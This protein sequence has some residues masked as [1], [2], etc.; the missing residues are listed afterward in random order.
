MSRRSFG[1]GRPFKILLIGDSSVGKTSLMFR[2]SDDKFT[3]TF[4]PTIGIDFKLK[5]I[6]IRDK[7]I[8]LQLWDTAGQERFYNIVR[9]YYRNADAI[10]LVYD[11]T[12]ACTFQNIVRWMKSINENAPDDVF[13]V[14][15]GNKSDLHEYLVVS[16]EDGRQLANQYHMNYFETSAKSDSIEKITQMFSY[17]TETL[18]ERRQPVSIPPSIPINKFNESTDTIYQ[19][20]T[21]CC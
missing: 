1:P 15:V 7:P 14:L 18:L 13:R 21:N 4:T 9:S 19:K 5:T 17:I 11:R 2:F 20:L 16:N 10:L 12:A 8:Q 3:Q 6:L